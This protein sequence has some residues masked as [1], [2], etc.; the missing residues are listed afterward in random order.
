VAAGA[1]CCDRIW[2]TAAQQ[3]VRLAV[4]SR[5]RWSLTLSGPV[6]RPWALRV[7]VLWREMPLEK[8]AICGWKLWICGPCWTTCQLTKEQPNSRQNAS[9]SGTYSLPNNAHSKA[10]LPIRSNLGHLTVDDRQVPG[11]KG[12][13]ELHRRSSEAKAQGRPGASGKQATR[14][15]LGWFVRLSMDFLSKTR[16]K[17]VQLHCKKVAFRSRTRPLCTSPRPSPTTQ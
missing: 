15:R 5:F 17:R 12:S 9:L 10:S 1:D 6:Y 2:C 7:G 16:I 4:S 13:S 8:P 14:Q 3:V 11:A